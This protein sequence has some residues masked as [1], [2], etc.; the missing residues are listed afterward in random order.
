MFGSLQQLAVLMVAQ[1]EAEN[2]G[3]QGDPFGMFM[4]L[5][6]VM[7][8][9]YF[10]LLRPQAK[11]RKNHEA[12]LDSL[13]RGDEVVTTSG[14]LGRVTDIADPFVTVEFARNTKIRVVKSHIAKKY[15]EPKASEETKAEKA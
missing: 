8:I 13:K 2:A 14:F 4:P 11:E 10:M 9:I 5:L 6:I 1:G 7:G 12:L 3:A 15:V